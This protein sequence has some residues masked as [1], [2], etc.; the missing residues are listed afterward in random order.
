MRIGASVKDHARHGTPRHDISDRMESDEAHRRAARAGR[1]SGQHRRADDVSRSGRATAC[2]RRGRGD[3][4]RVPSS[5]GRPFARSSPIQALPERAP[6][7]PQRA[8]SSTDPALRAIARPGLEPGTPRFS[9]ACPADRLWRR[10]RRNPVRFVSAAGSASRRPHR[11][12]AVAQTVACAESRSRYRERRPGASRESAAGSLPA[13]ECEARGFLL[14][15]IGPPPPDQVLVA[16]RSQPGGHATCRR[17][18]TSTRAPSRRRARRRATYRL[19]VA[20]R[21]C[22]GASGPA[23]P[24]DRPSRQR[25][26]AHERAGARCPQHQ[27]R[28][29]AWV[30]RF[31]RRRSAHRR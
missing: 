24:Q 23:R 5:T 20:G 21:S 17:G 31:G 15:R 4:T 13:M 2:S 11:R 29:A 9:A 18:S 12:E 10:L 7:T 22:V 6:D 8:E 27:H 25:R 16:H 30:G 14:G 1:R 19:A 3:G 28:W 26:A